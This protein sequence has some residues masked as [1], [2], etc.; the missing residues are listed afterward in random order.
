M[1]DLL[2]FLIAI[3]GLSGFLAVGYL[4]FTLVLFTMYKANGGRYSLAL[5]LK[6]YL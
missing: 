5:Y 2:F 3:G 6:K 1:Y 4:V